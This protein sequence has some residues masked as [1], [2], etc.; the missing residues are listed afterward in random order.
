MKKLNTIITA[1]TLAALCGCATNTREM[2][3]PDGSKEKLR[4]SVFLQ[5][6][7]G[8]AADGIG[9]DGTQWHMTVQNLTGDAVMASTIFQGIDSLAGKALLF[10]AGSNTNLQAVLNSAT[11]GQKIALSPN[12]LQKARRYMMLHAPSK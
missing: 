4:Q 12:E 2:T 3:Y 6:M 5:T 10:A 11:N 1:I 7:Q 9:L 8:Y